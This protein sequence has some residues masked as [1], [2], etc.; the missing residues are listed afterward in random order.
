VNVANGQSRTGR[1]PGSSNI[2][3][4]DLWC[5]MPKPMVPM[6]DAAGRQSGV[7]PCQTAFSDQALSLPQPSTINKRFR[8]CAGDMRAV[9]VARRAMIGS[10]SS[11]DR[12]PPKAASAPR[13]CSAGS[14]STTFTPR[15]HRPRRAPN[16]TCT[17]SPHLDSVATRPSRRVVRPS[18]PPARVCA[19]TPRHPEFASPGSAYHSPRHHEKR[20]P[21]RCFIG[22]TP[23]GPPTT[24]TASEHAI[25]AHTARPSLAYCPA[26][27]VSS[28][29]RAW[30][31][32]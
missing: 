22:F 1:R 28:I 20:I 6:H 9:K 5:V 27:V 16:N 23:R 17:P 30:W 29:S 31:L 18:P 4:C 32:H 14:A 13:S 19:L 2:E 25:A 8:C 12:A 26:T 11:H 21:G 7:R 15:E 24:P 10:R 3:C